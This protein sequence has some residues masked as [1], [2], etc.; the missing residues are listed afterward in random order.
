MPISIPD[1]DALVGYDP[2]SH[3]IA[4]LPSMMQPTAANAARNDSAMIE[5]Q[6][7]QQGLP[8]LQS[9]A[10]LNAAT[11]PTAAPKTMPSMAGPELAQSTTIPS[12]P[13][14]AP[15]VPAIAKP[16]KQEAMAAGKREYAEGL[17]TVTAE[18][19]TPEYYTQQLALSDYKRAHPEG[20]AISSDL[21]TWGKIKHGLALAGNVAGDILD[22]GAMERIP[23]TQLHEQAERNAW[24]AGIGEAAKNALTN[25]EAESWSKMVPI[26][27]PNGETQ[28]V[29]ERFAGTLG[30]AGER[31][32]VSERNTDVNAQ[33]RA[34]DVAAQQA[35]ANQRTAET[36]AGAAAREQPKTVVMYDKDPSEGG[37]L[38]Q[39][40]YDPQTKQFKQLNPAPPTAASL[41]LFGSVQPLFNPQTGEMIGTFNTKSGA[42]NPL[43][44][45]QQAGVAAMGGG[46]TG[47][48]PQT[49]TGERLQ[50]TKANQFNTQYVNPAN[51][52][53]QQ[54]QRATE[55]VNAYNNNP[56]TGAAA[57]VLFAQH[58]GTTLG[59]IKGAA[60]GE[61]AQK[62]HQDA[63]GLED[64]A[65]RFVDY[66]KTGQPLSANQVRD[67][68][69]LIQ[70]TRT[71]QWET[72]AR[73]AAR[74]KMP[75]DFLPSDVQIR[76]SDSKGESREVPANQVQGYV[77]RGLTI[78]Y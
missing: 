30:A 41:G 40:A 8:T 61:G 7:A 76:M 52:A 3:T 34:E 4:G 74:R 1:L 59:G 77:D 58:L 69:S 75:I 53:E 33:T 72:T 42:M 28:Y 38:Y 51:Q 11:H 46:A 47:A 23:G 32:Q 60:I 73:E 21:G 63:I 13:I 12:M 64:R 9:T 15:S 44:A 66:L 68:Y 24:T 19:G 37:K 27:G 29:P 54:Y 6:R 55:A 65:S 20:S 48:G 45:G 14:S 16:T 2:A 36:Q 17:P 31:G 25:A 71:L 62:M 5:A 18:P 50:N 26:T 22:P 70:Q 35:G 10:Y 56:K 57:M 39:Y 78:G 67:F 43:T 49:A